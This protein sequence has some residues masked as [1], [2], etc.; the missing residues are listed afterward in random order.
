M[1]DPT[2]IIARSRLHLILPNET[3]SAVNGALAPELENPPEG[4]FV[5]I[6][7]VK[8]PFSHVVMDI[9]SLDLTSHRASLNSYLGLVQ[10]AVSALEPSPLEK[11]K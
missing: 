3:S 2:C 9:A 1:I 7:E 6:D 10:A 8:E 11:N 5:T 4:S